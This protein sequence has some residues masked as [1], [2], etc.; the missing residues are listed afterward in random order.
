MTKFRNRVAVTL[1]SAIMGATSIA[2][3]GARAAT[4]PATPAPTNTQTTPATPKLSDADLM[5]KI[6]FGGDNTYLDT[7]NPEYD[8]MIEM[9]H[10]LAFIE[11]WAAE[12]GIDDLSDK[13]TM[14]EAVNS[15]ITTEENANYQGF[16]W[17]KFWVDFRPLKQDDKE[18]VKALVEKYKQYVGIMRASV[19]CMSEM[20]VH[21]ILEEMVNIPLRDSEWLIPNSPVPLYA[22]QEGNPVNGL[23]D[24]MSV[25]NYRPASTGY[26][27]PNSETL[28]ETIINYVNIDYFKN[29]EQKP[30]TEMQITVD[31]TVPENGEREKGSGYERI[32]SVY[33]PVK[34][35]A[36][37]L[38]YFIALPSNLEYKGIKKT[39]EVDSKGNMVYT[40]EPLSTETYTILHD[41]LEGYL[42]LNPGEISTPELT[43]RMG[44]TENGEQKEGA[45]GKVWW[46]NNTMVPVEALEYDEAKK[47]YVGN[48]GMILEEPVYDL[49]DVAE[50]LEIQ[51][52][53]SQMTFPM[54]FLYPDGKNAADKFDEYRASVYGAR[55]DARR[56]EFPAKAPAGT[57]KK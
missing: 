49:N 27:V 12:L 6:G 44:F 51:R 29:P 4:Q 31:N 1:M 38:Y 17:E 3:T 8:S 34:E 20:L 42:E 53:A 36:E 45:D 2:G 43:D 30:V 37:E 48:G 40:I 10:S 33:T 5:M 35:Y 41:A 50:W 52:T 46:I 47:M 55:N 28:A 9:L 15:L 26:G 22:D 23:Y 19:A 11:E 25:N 56:L 21:A 18:A 39:T 7:C 57:I 54:T 13:F 16:T 24:F 32:L 14:E